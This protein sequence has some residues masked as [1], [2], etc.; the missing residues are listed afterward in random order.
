MNTTN[1]FRGKAIGATFFTGFGA[2]WLGL[3]LYIREI[4]STTTITLLVV[5]TLSLLLGCLWTYRQADQWPEVPEDP[6]TGR[7]FNRINAAQWI[8]IAV[9]AFSFARLHLDAYV[10]SAITAIVGVHLFPLARLFRRKLHLVTGSLLVLWASVTV[11]AVPVEH[12][13]GITALGTG[14]ILWVSAAISL[15][16][17]IAAARSRNTA[18]ASNPSLMA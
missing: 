10:L 18:A 3:S 2:I 4:L 17:G 12:M 13:Q 5:G 15:S 6:A 11:L 9:V 1:E 14:I 16:T 8:A 7:I